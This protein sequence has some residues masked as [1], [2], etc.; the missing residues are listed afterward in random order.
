MEQFGDYGRFND[1]LYLT[2][3]TKE[4]AKQI[5]NSMYH[6]VDSLGLEI[7]KKKTRIVKATHVITFLKTRFNLLDNGDVLRRPNRK[8]ISRE[9][10]KLKKLHNKLLNGEITFEDV[11]T[12]YNSWRG[13]LKDKKCYLT[14]ESMDKLFNILFIEEWRFE[15]YEQERQGRD[16]QSNQRCF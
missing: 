13:S 9:R 4:E 11:R 14:L 16:I 10:R 12:S 15:Y 7:N 3:Q 5:L 8:S 6:I 2:V 1:D